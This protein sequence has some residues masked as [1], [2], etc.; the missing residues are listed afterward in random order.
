MPEKI[1]GERLGAEP[2]EPEPKRPGAEPVEPKPKRP[3]AEPEPPKFPPFRDPAE[4]QGDAPKDPAS[5][6][7]AEILKGLGFCGHYMHFHGGGRSGKIPILCML[8]RRG[9]QM[10]QQELGGCFDIKPGSLSEILSKLESA[11]L[12]ERT[13]D[14]KDRRQLFV[15]LTDEG[16]AAA[17]KAHEGREAFRQKAFACLSPEEQEQ[18][19]DM[20]ARIRTTWKEID[21]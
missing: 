14:P 8:D 21:A 11:G 5:I 6:R 16:F 18:L 19:I 7:A 4:L 3:A 9:G 12:I 15:H 1:Q 20:L 17:R 10:S 13:R 2:V